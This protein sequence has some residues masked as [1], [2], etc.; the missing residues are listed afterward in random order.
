MSYKPPFPPPPATP[1]KAA[2]LESE[3]EKW[4][5]L[6]AHMTPQ[7]E[8]QRRPDPIYEVGGM[9][10]DAH[11]MDLLRQE[12]EEHWAPAERADVEPVELTEGQTAHLAS[13]DC[14]MEVQV[15]EGCCERTESD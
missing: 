14:P 2:W 12:A 13:L 10:T 7:F 9:A 4:D 11:T 8:G 15:K 5:A 6:N 3:R 1:E